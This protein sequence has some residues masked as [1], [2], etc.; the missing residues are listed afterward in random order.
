MCNK[1]DL[2]LKENIL[3]RR[4]DTFE[5]LYEKYSKLVM[6]FAYKGTGNRRDAEDLVQEIF[7]KLYSN[8]NTFNPYKSSFKTWL[9]TI[10]RNHVIDFL[11]NKK[12]VI[13]DNELI[14]KVLDNVFF[15]EKI[16]YS[17]RNLD[18]LDRDIL[19]LKAIFKFTHKEISEAYHIT[20]DVCKKHYAA[21]KAITRRDWLDYEKRF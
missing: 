3:L 4:E 10:T 17:I 14:D 6:Y 9:V 5:M 12:E 21:A 20:E 19:V 15:S 1:R 8:I 16:E 11:K 13:Y 18:D 2:K 7:M